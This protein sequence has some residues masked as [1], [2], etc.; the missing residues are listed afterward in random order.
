[1]FEMADAGVGAHSIAADLNEA[2]VDTW[3]AGGWKA[4]Y[5]HRS[6]VRKIL[7]NKVTI[8]IFTPHRVVKVEGKRA[9]QRI[10]EEP[11][12]HRFPAVVDRELFERVN[13]RISTT[14][15]R[16]KNAGAPTRSVFAGVMRCQHCDGNVTRVSKGQ[17]VYLV[18]AAAHAKAGTHP[19]E[20]VPYVEAVKAF[21]G[22]LMRTLDEA[23]RGKDTAE[24]DAEIERLSVEVDAGEDAV[25][26][27]LELAI[28][29]KSR[30]ARQRLQDIERELDEQR[31]A[32]RKAAERRDALTST[33]VKVRLDAVQKA[34]TT[35]PMDTE[36]ANKALRGA[37]SRMVMRPQVGTLEILWHHVDEPQDTL[38]LT[39]RYPWGHE[40]GGWVY[41]AEE[42]TT[43]EDTETQ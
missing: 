41:K 23:P 37:V 3:G 34:F 16:G 14:E 39:S 11:I 30:A 33:N 22:G 43:A 21:R 1:M 13:A 2:K 24:W 19:Y 12:A 5:W 7:A 36:A 27:L 6:Y 4:K 9:K 20:S 15:A 42:H 29:D 35:E 17:Y 10:A 8:G 18:C 32:L 25:N 40:P 28:A 31:E 38:F 26:E